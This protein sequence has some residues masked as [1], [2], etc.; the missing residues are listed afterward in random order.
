MP[1][2]MVVRVAKPFVDELMSLLSKVLL[3]E[4]GLIRQLALV[5]MG[6]VAVVEVV[7]VVQPVQ[8][9]LDQFH[10][11][12]LGE[13]EVECGMLLLVK[14]AMVEVELELDMALLELVVLL[15]MVP[16][17]VVLA[18]LINQVMGAQVCLSP[19]VALVAVAV[20]VPMET[21]I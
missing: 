12:E 13:A 16:R 2:L 4:G 5:V 20:V 3:V 14:K 9:V 8:E 21:L 19:I 6:L 17:M 1:L 18:A 15:V 11:E 10:W 7:A